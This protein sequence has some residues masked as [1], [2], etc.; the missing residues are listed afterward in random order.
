MCEKCSMFQH[1][2]FCASCGAP[3]TSTKIKPKIFI[4]L[5]GGLVQQIMATENMDVII[6]DYDD[7]DGMDEHPERTVKIDGEDPAY[8]Y[9]G[10]SVDAA[11]DRVIDLHRQI[12]TALKEKE[13]SQ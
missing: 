8:I 10:A 12:N 7:S 1:W 13:N 2:N 9:R 5:S 3:L 11:P 6:I 4:D